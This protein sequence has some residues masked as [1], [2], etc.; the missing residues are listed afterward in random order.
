MNNANRA[1]EYADFPNVFDVEMLNAREVRAYLIVVD[2]TNNAIQRILQTAP[3]RSIPAGVI[4]CSLRPRLKELSQQYP[5]PRY[6]V[7]V[8][9]G[10]LDTVMAELPLVRGWDTIEELPFFAEA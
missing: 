1:T 3:I 6:D 7:I 10:S 8:A 2:T 9:Q 5:S 4:L